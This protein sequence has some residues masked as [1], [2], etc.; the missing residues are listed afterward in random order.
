M[1]KVEAIIRPERVALVA[2]ALAEAGFIGLN[3]AHVT[4]R[5]VQ[6]GI[7]HVGRGGIT[8]TVDMLPK[9]KLEVVCKD[10]D[11]DKVIEIIVESART[12]EIGDGKIFVT[13]VTQ[14]VRVRTGERGDAAI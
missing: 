2:E 8:V 9:T 12:G 13:P 6:K 1:N 3:V 11:V 4:G 5:G 7:Q 10:A 14:T